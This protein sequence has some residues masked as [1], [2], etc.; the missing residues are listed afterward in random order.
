[1]TTL[2]LN[3]AAEYTLAAMDSGTYSVCEAVLQG[4][5]GPPPKASLVIEVTD[6]GMVNADNTEQPWNAADPRA[7]TLEGMTTESNPL[8]NWNVWVPMADT[9]VGMVTAVI[10]E[11]LWNV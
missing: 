2:Q 10:A 1:M 11:Q 5:R 8:Q 4:D 9:E 7:V 3:R 6:K